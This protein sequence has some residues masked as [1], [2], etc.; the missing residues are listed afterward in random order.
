[1]ETSNP[2]FVAGVVVGLVIWGLLSDWPQLRDAL[3][4]VASTSL[5]DV[6]SG[7]R[8]SQDGSMIDRLSAGS[9]VHPDFI[10]GAIFAATAATTLSLIAARQRHRHCRDGDHTQKMRVDE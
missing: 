4:A 2:D 7:Q 5:L 10:L 1:M 9:P 6:L 3:V 8:S